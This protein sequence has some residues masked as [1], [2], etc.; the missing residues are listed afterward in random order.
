MIPI[1]KPTLPDFASFEKELRGFFSTGMITNFYYVKKLEQTLQEALGVKYAIAVSS[2]TSGLMLVMKA[3]ELKGEVI[4]PSFTFSAS[5]HAVMWNGLT[6]KFVDINPETYNIDPQKVRE[7]INE[8]TSAILGVH[9]FG[10]PADVEE[11]EK[12]SREHNLKLIFDAAHGMGSKVGLRSVGSFGNAEVF[13]CS[14]TKLMVTGEGGIVTTNDDELARKIR[15]GRNYG[16]GGN[17]D[18]EFPGL[19]ARMSEFNALLGLKTHQSLSK[20]VEQRNCLVRRYKQNLQ[21][22]P[23]ISF[24]KIDDGLKTTFKDFSLFI[25][26]ELFGLDRNQLAEKLLTLNVQTKKYFYPPLHEQG[27]YAKF[28]EAYQNILPVTAKISRGVL[29]IPL[30]SHM[31]TEEVDQVCEAIQTIH[32]H[33]LTK[34]A[35][36]IQEITAG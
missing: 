26:P 13:S 35:T 32:E 16:D 6:P 22:V 15:I 21:N 30:Y 1:T 25:D 23:G 10:C 8:N 33:A 7:A 3:L 17:Y 12:I 34:E 24:Q 18:C 19:N 31:T 2:C 29:S 36:A 14:P 4:L 9:L 28:K 27:A 5:G 11:L 20:N